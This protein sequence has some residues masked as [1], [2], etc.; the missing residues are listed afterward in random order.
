[1]SATRSF[2]ACE[3]EVE[4]QIRV[5]TP[6]ATVEPVIEASDLEPDEKA[7]VWLACWSLI[8]LEA[9]HQQVEGPASLG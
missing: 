4:A 5:R 9:D 6:L 7:A 8:G 1:M 3:H 2:R